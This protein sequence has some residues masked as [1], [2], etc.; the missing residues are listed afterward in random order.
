[1]LTNFLLAIIGVFMYVGANGE[2]RATLEHLRLAGRHVGD[3]MLV[4]P[5]TIDATVTAAE[6]RQLVR[7]NAQSVF[8]V[9]R[10]GRYVGVVDVGS[11][12]RAPRRGARR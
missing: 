4:M 10:A 3:A 8:P 2:E 6:L 12:R 11:I 7:R 5:T 1:M 9:A